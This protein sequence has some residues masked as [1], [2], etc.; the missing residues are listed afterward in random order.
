MQVLRLESAGARLWNALSNARERLKTCE[1]ELSDLRSE[2]DAL[3]EKVGDAERRACEL[4]G[5]LEET[6]ERARGLEKGVE[7]LS[8]EWVAVEKQMEVMREELGVAR[9]EKDQAREEV[10]ILKKEKGL[11][12]GG[13][14]GMKERLA[15]VRGERDEEARGRK[16]AETALEEAL[17]SYEEAQGLIEGALVE[18]E[19]AQKALSE[20]RIEA[21]NL[22]NR[23]DSARLDCKQLSADLQSAVSELSALASSVWSGLGDSAAGG[24][25][26]SGEERKR[27]S[28]KIV[29]LQWELERAGAERKRLVQEAERL[30]T[31]EKLSYEVRTRSWTLNPKQ[32]GKSLR[33]EDEL[34][35]KARMP[36]SP[37]SFFFFFFFLFLKLLF[38]FFFLINVL[39]SNGRNEPFVQTIQKTCNPCS[40]NSKSENPCYASQELERAHDEIRELRSEVTD[41]TKALHRKGTSASKLGDDPMKGKP[42]QPHPS[43]IPSAAGDGAKHR[44]PLEAATEGRVTRRSARTSL[45]SHT[46]ASAARQSLLS[47]KENAG[48]SNQVQPFL[49]KKSS[50]SVA[51]IGSTQELVMKLTGLLETVEGLSD[52]A[53]N[54]RRS[55][56]T[57]RNSIDGATRLDSTTS[58]AECF[59]FLIVSYS[60]DSHLLQ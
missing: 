58:D 4:E 39:R 46:V 34:L 17:R 55:S 56:S 1:S 45:S 3:L 53:C 16:E 51:G 36:L 37:F 49:K 2:R 40:S 44:R 29:Q 10:L 60:L 19:E 25:A 13:E 18:A 20:S 54:S 14:G 30:Q 23:L 21:Q 32:V 22:S 7:G 41:L 43:A 50:L 9:R 52:G 47:D 6:K 35:Y 59:A 15:E 28:T 38:L 8:E 57:S 11:E 5:E 27:L 26:V 33:T 42:P 31:E 48:N 24:K 12:G